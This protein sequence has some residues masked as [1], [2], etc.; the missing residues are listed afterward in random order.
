MIGRREIFKEL[1]RKYADELQE[2]CWPGKVEIAGGLRRG[3]RYVDSK[4]NSI[5]LV[6]CPYR[7]KRMILGKEQIV[8]TPEI[9]V[10]AGAQTRKPFKYQADTHL[11]FYS[12]EGVKISVWFAY[13]ITWGAVLFYRTGTVHYCGQL[14]AKL[15]AKGLCYY[16]NAVRRTRAHRLDNI[17]PT[18]TEHALFKLAGMKYVAPSKRSLDP[19]DN[20]VLG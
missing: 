14:T 16:R 11:L 19:R 5:D 2:F 18:Q 15:E 12:S 3:Q 17:V 20:I 7:K 8:I 4:V 6:C 9:R 1:A 10:W 13:K